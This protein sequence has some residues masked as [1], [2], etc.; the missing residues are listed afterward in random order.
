[1]NKWWRP[2]RSRGLSQRPQLP[3][4]EL[5]VARRACAATGAPLPGSGLETPDPRLKGVSCLSTRAGWKPYLKQECWC[6]Q[7]WSNRSDGS[8]GKE[9]NPRWPKWSR[10]PVLRSQRLSPPHLVSRRADMEHNKLCGSLRSLFL[11]WASAPWSWSHRGAWSGPADWCKCH[12]QGGGT[13]LILPW[14]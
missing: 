3:T 7:V 9:A 10:Y 12:P 1:M 2:C 11:L 14:P 6:A 8:P 13:R 5:S 4:K